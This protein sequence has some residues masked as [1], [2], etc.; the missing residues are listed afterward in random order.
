MTS[1]ERI[2]AVLA[3]QKPDRTPFALVDGGAWIA[4]N[5]NMS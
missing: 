4:M 3:H 2:D 5:E 1:K